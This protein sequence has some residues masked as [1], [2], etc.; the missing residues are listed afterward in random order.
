MCRGA[1]LAVNMDV[2]A[3]AP[4]LADVLE[5]PA[6]DETITLDLPKISVLHAE[7]F[8][9]PPLSGRILRAHLASFLN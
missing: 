2:A 1:T 8:R 5:V 6:D 9:S 4:E 3:I 7:F